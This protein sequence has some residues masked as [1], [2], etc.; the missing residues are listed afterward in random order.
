MNI[1]KLKWF[2]LIAFLVLSTPL[3]AELQ[4]SKLFSDHMVLQRDKANRVWGS[5]SPGGPVEICVSD[6]CFNGK[7]GD[8]GE[9]EITLP[10]SMY[11]SSFSRP[12]IIRR[13]TLPDGVISKYS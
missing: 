12:S 13:L 2:L 9:W 7:A 3:H 11:S 6:K 4:I 8:S 10:G 1:N 5:T